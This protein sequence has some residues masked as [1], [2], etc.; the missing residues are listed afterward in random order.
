[1]TGFSERIRR[2]GLAEKEHDEAIYDMEGFTYTEIRMIRS[3]VQ[4]RIENRFQ[5]AAKAASE[6]NAKI[7]DSTNTEIQRLIALKQKLM[8]ETEHE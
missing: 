2:M 6:M 1:M 4:D 8:E 5:Y 3:L 7:L